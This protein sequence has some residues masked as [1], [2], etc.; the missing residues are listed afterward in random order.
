MDEVWRNRAQSVE[1][2]AL[3]R[4]SDD[5]SSGREFSGS[6]IPPTPWKVQKSSFEHPKPR[7]NWLPNHNMSTKKRCRR[8]ETLSEA[9]K[10]ES[11]AQIQ[12]PDGSQ[13]PKGLVRG[14]GD[15]ID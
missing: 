9:P 2:A 14:G 1:N 6:A 8:E 7:K 13:W 5:K 4:R 10:S 15:K 3:T 12:A 11:E